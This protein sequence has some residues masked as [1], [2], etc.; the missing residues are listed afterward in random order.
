MVGLAP[1]SAL[2]WP[3][4]ANFSSMV[5]AAAAWTNLPKRVPVLAKPQEGTSMRKSSSAAQT[6]SASRTMFAGIVR[7]SSQLQG[8][9]PIE[10]YSLLKY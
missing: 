1:V 8:I 10:I 7:S 2:T 6:R 5:V 3:A 9:C 4:S